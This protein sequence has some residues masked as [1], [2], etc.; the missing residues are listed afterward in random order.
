MFGSRTEVQRCSLQGLR[1]PSR[2]SRVTDQPSGWAS[3]EIF[4]LKYEIN[5]N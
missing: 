4:N 5:D 3:H 2:P 1:V